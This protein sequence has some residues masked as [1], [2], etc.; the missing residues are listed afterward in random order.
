VCSRG[1][2]PGT[3]REEPDTSAESLQSAGP[4]AWALEFAREAL[5]VEPK[6]TIF[7]GTG[8]ILRRKR[9]DVG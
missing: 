3:G 9:R 7:L 1:Y 5:N 4:A 8:V 6:A 2:G